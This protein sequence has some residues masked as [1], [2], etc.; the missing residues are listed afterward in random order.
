MPTLPPIVVSA[1]TYIVDNDPNTNYSSST[2]VTVYQSSGK[3][4][5]DYR[6]LLQFSLTSVPANIRVTEALLTLY[7]SGIGGNKA[8][9][10]VAR[11]TKDVVVSQ[12]TWNQ[13]STGN[14][15]DTAGGDISS[16]NV[17]IVDHQA[18][19]FDINITGI[20]QDAVD[21]GLSQLNLRLAQP[22]TPPS[23]AWH[24][25]SLENGVDPPASLTLSYMFKSGN[26]SSVHRLFLT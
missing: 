15:W 3:F 13:Y 11:V 24:V 7:G 16:D 26:E 20:L 4:T 10:Q 22:V 18:L 23:A 12:A 1:D 2:D 19:S 25:A 9:V 6:G 21:L 14:N 8:G 17:V 5:A